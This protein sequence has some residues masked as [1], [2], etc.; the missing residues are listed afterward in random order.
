MKRERR[1]LADRELQRVTTRRPVLKRVKEGT[2]D[3]TCRTDCLDEE[4]KVPG[5]TPGR[6]EAESEREEPLDGH[7]TEKSGKASGGCAHP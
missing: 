3:N 6:T 2:A 7:S 4:T 5:R 1:K